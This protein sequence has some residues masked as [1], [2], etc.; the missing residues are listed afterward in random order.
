MRELA[1]LG[2]RTIA[3]V[4]A[5][6]PATGVALVATTGPLSGPRGRPGPEQRPG[7]RLP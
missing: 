2:R 5:V 1:R 6:T 3:T 7:G 4:V